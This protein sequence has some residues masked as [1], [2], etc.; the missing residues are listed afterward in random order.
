MIQRLNNELAEIAWSL[1]TELGVAGTFR[2]HKNCLISLEELIIL[3]AAIADY[4]PRLRDEALDWCSR[5]HHFV[6]VNRLKT[7]VKK[8]GA[9]I[10]EPFST[11]ASTLNTI[12]QSNWP[13]FSEV[14]PLKFIPSNKSVLPSLS[15]PALLQLRLRSFFGVGARADLFT[16]LLTEVKSDFTASDA[17]EIGYSKRSLAELLDNLT[18]SG[19]LTS[20]IIRNQRKYELIRTEQLKRVVGEPPEI[21]PPWHRILKVLI[22]LRDDLI[23]SEKDSDTTKVVI[24]RNDLERMK[25]LLSS[26]HLSPPSIESDPYQYLERFSRWLLEYTKTIAQGNFRGQFKVNSDFEKIISV[27]IQH[28]YKSDDCLDGL[29]FILAYSKENLIKHSDIYRES[30]QLSLN[31]INELKEDLQELLDFP[32]HQLMDNKISEI[33]YDYSKNHLQSFLNFNEKYTSLNQVNDP[34]Q[35]LKQYD[36]LQN[37]LSKLH[38]FMNELRD[39]LAK[40]YF[41]KTNINLLTLPS[42]LLKRH[43]VMKLYSS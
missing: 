26:V 31:F 24:I 40:I 27:L 10:F 4:D 7:L 5:Y 33:T 13:I 9:P 36:I 39:R 12:T 42:K 22:S 3:T 14:V 19:F 41:S 1:W 15:T 23:R 18:L 20:K 30:Y 34:R 21:V 38:N 43:A 35:A 8:I 16:Y 37:E 17:V 6:S 25:I 29:E 32:F 2:R 28:I 11:F